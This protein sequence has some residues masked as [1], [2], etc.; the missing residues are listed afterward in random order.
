MPASTPSK[1]RKSEASAKA[2]QP[3]TKRARHSLGKN[4][5]VE[6]NGLKSLISEEGD[7]RRLKA[8]MV[9][10][11]KDKQKSKVDESRSIVGSGLS[12]G[13]VD[14]KDA[15]KGGRPDIVEI[16]SDSSEDDDSDLEDDQDVEQDKVP[17]L[18][19]DS[20]SQAANVPSP[21]DTPMADIEDSKA[22][23]EEQKD[24]DAVIEEPSFG[25]LLQA[26]APNPID[27]D[28][29]LVGP[30]SHNQHLVPA[31]GNR[32]LSAPS[33]NSLGTV[34]TQALR[35]SDNQLLES[36]F[37]MTNLD[38]VRSTIERLSS[39]LVSSLLNKI[40]E[41]LHRRPGR[42]GHLMV[43]IQWSL[44]CHGGYL[45]TQPDVVRTLS[46]LNRVII[47]RSNG[48]QPLLSLKGKMDMLSAQLD[49]RK[50]MQRS[51]AF[52]NEDDEGVIYVE[53]QEVDETDSDAVEDVNIKPTPQ[54]S[55][56]RN[57]ALDFEV[58]ES[59]ESS[60]E[61]EDMPTTINGLGGS[62]DVSDEEDNDDDDDGDEDLLDDEAE[63]TDDD[64]S[65]E[66]ADTDDQDEDEISEGED[67][68]SED[69]A[70]PPKRSTTALR[71][72]FGR[73]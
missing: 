65:D 7:G 19:G 48:L 23:T 34:L 62:S 71:S 15:G 37:E 14:M 72:G 52:N 70:P 46:H 25:E 16:S 1:T 6:N 5:D 66:I 28:A 13:D 68:E 18:N 49:L 47:E 43:W 29:S 12:N 56:K 17:L 73:R 26:H 27:V 69:E 8:V 30:A 59:G 35:T 67:V 61:G 11:V 3:P 44:V 22:G 10:G 50:K 9:N 45:A 42:A 31:S 33:V 20:K 54:K 24:E 64:D 60:A 41:R 55:N 2:S 21:P 4:R 38:S 51:A 39:T 57:K 53:G 40:A 63:S 58:G 32:V 36:C